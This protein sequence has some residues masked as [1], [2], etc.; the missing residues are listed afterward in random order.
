MANPKPRHRHDKHDKCP[1]CGGNKQ[2]ASSLC[3]KCRYPR[4]EIEQPADTS[5]RYIPLT[6]EQITI[7]DADRYAWVMKWNWYALYNRLTR[8][9]YA[10]RGGRSGEPKCA[11]LHRQLV[12]EP[13]GEV[14]HI[15][16]DT[17]DN[18]LQNLRI[19]SH[20]Q[21]CANRGPHRNNTSGAV[22]VSRHENKWQVQIQVSGKEIYLGRFNAKED[23]IAARTVAEFKY[24]GEFA[25]SARDLLIL[26]PDLIDSDEPTQ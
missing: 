8:S 11:S 4:P 10:G 16:G 21:N 1:R 24:R 14:D 5:I 6:Q 2:V 18:R 17:L 9:Y 19:C 15:N 25:Y 7:V 22:G 12:G 13:D 26:P 23:A 20:I 3:R